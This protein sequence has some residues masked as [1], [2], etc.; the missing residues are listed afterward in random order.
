MQPF[1]SH[2]AS[3]VDPL[4]GL[5]RVALPQVN[6]DGIV[7]FLHSLFSVP[8]GLYSTASW[9]FNCH[10]ELPREGIPPVVDLTVKAF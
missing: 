9:L 1:L 4:P 6:L 10:V 2:L 8:I 7:L 5:E 3:R